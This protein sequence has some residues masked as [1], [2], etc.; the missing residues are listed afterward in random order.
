MRKRRFTENEMMRAVYQFEAIH[1]F[2][3]GNGRTGRILCI[4]YL[5]RKRILDL[6]ILYLSSHI[7]QDKDAYYQAFSGVSGMRNWKSFV[8]FMLEAVF[9]TAQYTTDKI[10]RIRSP[11]EKTHN[12]IRDNKIAPSRPE[13]HK[14]FERPYIRPKNLLSEK[15]QE[16][17]YGQEVFVRY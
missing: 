3:D 1:P 11:I 10:L 17:E 6:P 12:L 14:L 15:N 16:R 9:Q 2:R 8:S 4:L 5:I 13:V 7:L